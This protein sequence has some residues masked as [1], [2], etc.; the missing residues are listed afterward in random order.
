MNKKDKIKLII[1]AFLLV[2]LFGVFVLAGDVETEQPTIT[3]TPTSDTICI[4]GVCNLVAYSGIRN[5]YE[6]E[7]WKKIEN[8]RSLKGSGIECVVDSDGINLVEC[9]DWNMTHIE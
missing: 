3:S 6:D 4:D 9:V 5:V 1:I 8:A 7:T 2:S